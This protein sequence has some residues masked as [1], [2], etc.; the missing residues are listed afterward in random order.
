M[1]DTIGTLLYGFHVMVHPFDGYWELKHHKPK[2]T[3]AALII[4]LAALATTF[5]RVQFSGF[6]FGTEN[7]ETNNVLL[8]LVALAAP[9][10]L[11]CIV[12]WAITTLFN[13]KGKMADIFMFTSYA[14]LPMILIYLPTTLVSHIL[15]NDEAVF[16]YVAEA[17]AL[18][19]G[20]WMVLA[21]SSTVH[22]YTLFKSIF[23]G[24]FTL[25]GIMACVFLGMVIYSAISQLI[26]F[27]ITLFVE[28]RY[29]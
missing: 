20:V 27:F 15:S 16:L 1:R 18:I 28:F 26:G 8:D 12:N 9:L 6:L 10:T 7:P 22:D 13:G 21:G 24:L 25:V 4:F 14:L 3:R 17:V 5:I 2:A 11:W 23:T 29:W 19:W